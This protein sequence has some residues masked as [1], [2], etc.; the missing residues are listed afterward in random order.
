MV[1][2]AGHLKTAGADS[3]VHRN[4][5][6]QGLCGGS[7]AVHPAWTTVELMCDADHVVPGE[8]GQIRFFG[9]IRPK[10]AVGV[11]VRGALPR[12]ARI[13]VV[14]REPRTDLLW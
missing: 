3:I 10:E 2:F 7:P 5:W 12:A 6:C 4:G 1:D 9:R 8:A 13:A 14:H 11:R